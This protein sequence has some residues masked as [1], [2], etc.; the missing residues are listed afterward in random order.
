M[1][2]QLKISAKDFYEML[3]AGIHSTGDLWRD[4]PTFGMLSR[5][6]VTG[7]VVTPACDL[8]Q[9]KCETICY[10]PVISIKEYLSAPVFYSEIWKVIEEILSKLKF[11]DYVIP[12]NRFELPNSEEIIDSISKLKQLVKKEEGKRLLLERLEEYKL[13]LDDVLSKRTPSITRIEKIISKAKFEKILS[14]IVTNSFKSDIHFLPA[15][16]QR[17]TY[18]AI[19]KNSVVLFRYPLTAPITLLDK[20]QLCNQN[21]WHDIRLAQLATSPVAA[22]FKEWPVKLSRLKDDFL[23]DLLSRYIAMYIRLGSRDFTEDSI[24]Q[25]V[26]QVRG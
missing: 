2:A 1:P 5:S 13:Y 16:G 6:S 22:H 17:D 24:D 21:N 4:L 7:I 15:D 11:N 10:L 9:K 8:A 3:P 23:A 26:Q 18:S 25:F 12:P 19:Q 20:A 14:A